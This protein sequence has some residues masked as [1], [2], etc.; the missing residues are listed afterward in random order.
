MSQGFAK[1]GAHGLG[2]EGS[3]GGGHDHRGHLFPKALMG[4]AKDD[5]FT[6]AGKL[7]EGAL[8]LGAVHVFPAPEDHVLLPV[9]DGDEAVF[10][11]P[12]NVPGLKPT[13]LERFRRGLRAIPVAT[14]EVRAFHPQLPERT[15]GALLPLIIEG[16][17][18]HH[19]GRPSRAPGA[20]QVIIAI[21]LGAHRIT[22]REAVANA[23]AALE[24]RLDLTNLLRRRRRPAAPNGL[25]AGGVVL[26]KV[27]A[28]E[29][30]PGHGGH[31]GE[32]GHP[33][34]LNQGQR[35]LRIPLVHQY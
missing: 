13:I 9:F 3:A 16:F 32:G 7:V 21:V 12:A 2:F 26:V 22:F 23:R 18:G 4:Q 33:L 15:P 27:L 5:R 17:D 34:P 19:A 20:S 8:H 24:A 14:K 25:K 31:T 29:H 1:L 10:V 30:F 28:L 35:F 6:H 11:H